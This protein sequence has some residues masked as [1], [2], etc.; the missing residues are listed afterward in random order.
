MSENEIERNR[1][2][3]ERK[4]RRL[5]ELKLQRADKGTDTDP[6]V[7]IEI[8][9]TEAEIAKIQTSIDTM[10]AKIAKKDASAV[11]TLASPLAKYDEFF[12]RLFD[13]RSVWDRDESMFKL[14]VLA[15]LA[16]A[17]KAEAVFIA[18]YHSGKWE[19]VTAK[20][21][22]AMQHVGELIAQNTQVYMF[23]E[24]ATRH[25]RETKNINPN[26]PTNITFGVL[27]ADGR[28]C[29]LA[30]F[31]NTQPAEVLVLYGVKLDFEPDAALG[32]TLST[33]LH[34]TNNLTVHRRSVYVEN[35]V[36]NALRSQFGFVSDA[37][38]NQQFKLFEDRLKSMIVYFE[39]IISLS[40][41]PYIWRWEALARDPDTERAPVDLF[42]TAELWGRQ[43]QL[44]LDLHF[45]L[46]AVQAYVHSPKGTDDR[47]RARASKYDELLPLSV[48]VYPQ[49]LVR[50]AY[51]EAI[52][53]ID[54]KKLF[55][56]E[57]LTLE[58]S[59]KQD[60]TN[61]EK[62]D[63]TQDDMRW[64]REH[65]KHYAD[66]GISF[67]IDDFGVGYASTSRLSRIEPEFVKIDRDALLHHLGGFT[68]E[69]ALRL[70][71]ESLG[72]IKMIVEGFD[73]Q[74]KFSL[75][76]LYRLR[77]RYVQGYLLG[78]AEKSVYR[79]SDEDEQ[80][81]LKLLNR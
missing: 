44:E 5:H 46:T 32:A 73:D 12:K 66:Q 70:V 37:M 80:R 74:S 19:A 72:K 2:L 36:Y 47:S 11:K 9:D 58:I 64:F 55:P 50:R 77:I 42:E 20:D 34:V 30:V 22:D 41:T 24:Q 16:H 75:A 71:S 25:A 8:E 10:T 56:L 67:A 65:L 28:Y 61:P 6:R 15:S 23:L 69:Y 59:E 49:S 76:E 1:Q 48:N 18:R 81:I 4:S 13:R 27:P 52:A 78:K 26:I 62:Q 39:P 68:L 33:L 40:G 53:R 7:I 51:R 43:F 60:F 79:L 54:Q 35:A 17:A 14:N 38:Y 45:L 21:D 63:E 29:V 3:I 57:K 31:P